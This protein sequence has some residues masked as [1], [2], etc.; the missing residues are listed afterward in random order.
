MPAVQR[1]LLAA[2]REKIRQEGGR[3]GSFPTETTYRASVD[4]SAAKWRPNPGFDRSTNINT[5]NT[6]KPG[7]A[8]FEGTRTRDDDFKHWNMPKP[9][10]SKG[11][12]AP[13]RLKAKF[14]A[15]TEYKG[16]FRFVQLPPSQ[17]MPHSNAP[18]N[19]SKP[20]LLHFLADFVL[21]VLPTGSVSHASDR[22]CRRYNAL[23]PP[24]PAF[25]TIGTATTGFPSSTAPST[26]SRRQVPSSTRTPHT[27]RTLAMGRCTMPHSTL[28]RAQPGHAPS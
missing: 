4:A 15:E 17:S 1:E 27:G 20:T 12:Q 26:T 3:R 22:W 16:H 10:L 24:R 25:T 14:N 8:K 9:E 18:E 2:E 19:R 7:L 11:Y 5:R 28:Q 23:P 6:F 13:N 21:S